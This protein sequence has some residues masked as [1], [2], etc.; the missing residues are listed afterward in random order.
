[1]AYRTE[2]VQTS[3]YGMDDLDSIPNRGRN[4]FDHV[5]TGSAPP[6]SPQLPNHIIPRRLLSLGL[7]GRSVKLGIRGAITPLRHTP[8]SR[9]AYV[10]ERLYLSSPSLC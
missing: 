5:H 10:E 4:F 3:G 2:N 9:D 6:P 8:S 1:M 7:S